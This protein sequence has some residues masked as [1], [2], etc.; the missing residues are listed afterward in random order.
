MRKKKE[1]WK[2]LDSI[3]NEVWTMLERGVAETEDPFHWPVLGTTSAEGFSQRT[4]ILRQVNPPERMLVCYTDAR[5]PK[6]SEIEHSNRVGWLFYHPKEKVQLRITGQAELHGD[7]AFADAQWADTGITSRLNYCAAT[8]PG[9]PVDRPSSGLPDLM[10]NKLP[11]LLE[12]EK[13]RPNF[14]SIA[15]RI[16]SIDW[17]ILSLL[18]NR[19]ARF[20]WNENELA[21]NWLVP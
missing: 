17:L 14:M 5:A 6:V 2:T 10:I 3:L 16:D 4:V 21:S 9:T 12:S 19:R 20:Q 15:C 1:K 18:G 8:P 11:T 13:G 7:D